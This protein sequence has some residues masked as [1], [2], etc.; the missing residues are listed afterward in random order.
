MGPSGDTQRKDRLVEE[1]GEST[2]RSDSRR[3]HT[4]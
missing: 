3:R 2:G 4:Y 1:G